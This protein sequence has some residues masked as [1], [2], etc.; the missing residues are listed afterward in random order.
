LRETLCGLSVSA[1]NA[2]FVLPG[3]LGQVFLLALGTAK[4]QILTLQVKMDPVSTGKINLAIRVLDHDVV[5]LLGF[6]GLV[7]S[8]YHRLEKPIT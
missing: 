5:D 3:A 7:A 1:R 6:G 4:I 2:L 8:G